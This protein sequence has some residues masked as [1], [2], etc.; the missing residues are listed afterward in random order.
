[1]PTPRRFQT[2]ADRQAAYR[3]RAAETRRQ[4]LQRKGLPPTPAIPSMP[5]NARW[6]AL[7]ALAAEATA[8]VAAEMES[9][10]EDRS[11]EWQEGEKGET[12]TERL[13]EVRSAAESVAE[14]ASSGTP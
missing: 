8:T 12:F 9:Y 7:L 10:F 14:V 6:N 2:N 4:E 5:G 13:D 3:Q 1:M 11:E